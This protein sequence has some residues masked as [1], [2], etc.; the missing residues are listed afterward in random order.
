M[1]TGIDLSE[2]NG[3][4]R[5]N[6]FGFGDVHFAFIKATEAIDSIDREFERNIQCAKELGIVVGAYHWLHPRLHVGQ[7][8][9]LFIKTVR[10]F[11]GLLPPVVCLETHRVSLEEMEKNV[12]TYLD[13]VEKSVGVKPIIYTSDNYWKTYLSKAEWGCDYMLWLDKPGSIWPQQLWPWAG[14]TFWQYSYQAKLPGIPTNLGL[15]WFNGSKTELCQ[16]VIQ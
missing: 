3:E 16:M 7:Q 14:W 5:W 2:K 8:A 9:E 11:K 10:S 1:I 15:N 13:T 6:D 12:T 4:V